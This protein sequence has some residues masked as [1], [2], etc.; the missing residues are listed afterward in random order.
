MTFLDAGDA[1]AIERYLTSRGVVG[2]ADAP[3]AIAAAGAGNMN[4][5]LR[6]TLASGRTLVLK[7]GRPW[8]E[9]YPQIPAPAART[10]VEAAFYAEVQRAPSVAA[11]M[12]A[13]VHFDPD[14]HVL[15]LEDLGGDGDLTSM[16]GAATLP[17]ETLAALL[18]WLEALA[19]VSVDEATRPLFANRAMRAL[20]H[21]HMFRFPLA[22]DNGLDLNAVTPGLADAARA[23][24]DDSGYRAAVAALGRE[25]LA[26]GSTLVHGDYFPGS[27]LTAGG[28]IRIIDP[29]FCFLGTP[30]FDAGILAAHL[31]LAGG[32]T[33]LLAMVADAIVRRRLDPRR[34][35]G[36]AGVEI[37]RRLIGVAQ[38]P[39][40]YGLDR[41][42]A[43]LDRSRRLVLD[44]QQGLA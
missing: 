21:E 14:E 30:E 16:Y 7:Q 10:L 2:A 11:M 1:A 13:V 24:A 18:A 3:I 37:M 23:L 22:A 6:V 44:P 33:T 26:D 19:A 28:G 29:E 25:Y 4:L 8:V 9:K 38:L 5:T 40:A 20:N 31:L 34:V 43:L 27:W 35:A 12:P 39:L 41:K 32:G 42:R 36:Y 15:V 17:A